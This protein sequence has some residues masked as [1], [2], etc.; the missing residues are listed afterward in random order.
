VN[1]LGFLVYDASFRVD[2]FR[3]K[4]LRFKG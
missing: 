3:V 2:C 4:G 1:G